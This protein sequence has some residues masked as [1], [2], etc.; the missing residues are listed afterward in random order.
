MASNKPDTFFP[1]PATAHDCS[2]PGRIKTIFLTAVQLICL[3]GTI[4][5]YHFESES[6]LEQILPLIFFGYLVHESLPLRF[7]LPFFF[8][9]TLASIYLVTGAYTAS[10]IISVGLLFIGISHLPIKLNL[11]IALAILIAVLFA[12]L[13][14]RIIRFQ[15]LHAAIPFLASMFM[16]RW[17][18]YLYELRYEKKPASVWQRISYF[19]MLPNVCF[20]LFPI[21]DYK[22]FTRNYYNIRYEE[23][24]RKAILKIFRGVTHLLAYRVIYYFLV[25]APS[26]IYDFA[27]LAQ[28]IIFSY[29]L[30]LRLSGIFHLTLGIIGLFGFDLPE[31]F[32][33]YFLASS[34]SD[35]WRRINQ[36]W[37]EFVI[38]IFYQPIFF[39]L[40]DRAG[41]WALP[42]TVLVVFV[43]N[44]LLHNYQWFWIHGGIQRKANDV[45][46]WMVFG[47]TVM[48][49]SLYQQKYQSKRHTVE[50]A[51]WRFDRSLFKMLQIAGIFLFMCVLWSLWCSSSIAEWLFLFSFVN[52]VSLA[53]ALWAVFFIILFIV[54]GL[55]VDRIS[56]HPR[57]RVL[58]APVQPGPQLVMT[59]AFIL[60]ILSLPQ[61]HD[62]FDPMSHKFI[63]RLQQDK[64]NK[65]DKLMMERGYYQKM[66]NDEGAISR[67]MLKPGK[68]RKKE[69]TEVNNATRKTGDLLEVELLPLTRVEFKGAYI[70]TNSWGMRDQEYP[71]EK[72]ADVYRVAILGGSYEMGS[73]VEDGKNFESLA[74]NWLNSHVKSEKYKRFECLDFGVGGYHIFQNVKVCQE[75]A[76]A[77]SPNTLLLFAHSHEYYRASR[78]LSELI[79]NKVD[80]E[81]SFLK[82]VINLSGVKASMCQLEI[83]RKLKPYM[84]AIIH[85]AYFTISHSCTEKGVTPVWIYLPGIDD[86]MDATELQDIEKMARHS[87]FLTL[88]MEGIYKNHILDSLKLS[89]WDNHPNVKGHEIIAE[90]LVKDLILKRKELKF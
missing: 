8:L 85:W 73:G 4:I 18:L 31:I 79:V 37:R 54:V 68:D 61:V 25:P 58:L 84:P 67:V 90:D 45:L 36:Y 6:H 13:H 39:Q 89:P 72:A 66:L 49:N 65:A 27:D 23:G 71:K 1:Q 30:I 53:Q 51:G 55:L 81:Y 48:A 42:V 87:G 75:K 76:L 11:R 50:T 41:K 80:L 40:R 60:F 64:L 77:F 26:D 34:F 83:E 15:P 19:F 32:N 28:Y 24:Q 86:P 57:S 12:L 47:T 22:N 70:S 63:T 82:D 56:Q 3:F 62:H 74:E 2:L 88:S 46:F 78:K 43:I 5:L 16:F 69:W 44:W 52:H 20:P 17:I 29:M 7:R 38:K 33:N 9:L 59:Y 10:V 35:L 21:V 14:V